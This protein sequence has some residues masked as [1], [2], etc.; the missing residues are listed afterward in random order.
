MNNLEGIETNNQVVEVPTDYKKVAIDYLKNMGMQLPQK[1]ATQFIEIAKLYNLNPFKREIYA[2]GYGQNFNI[3]VGYEVYLK[4][5]ER[6]GTLDG[7]EVKTI[8]EGENMVSE[9]TIWRKDRSHPYHRTFKFREFAQRK[10]DGTLNKFWKEKPSF[11]L[12]KV[13]TAI[14]FRNYFPDELGGMPYTA[15][16]LPLDDKDYNN[17]KSAN[18]DDE[19]SPEAKNLRNQEMENHST[20][21]SEVAMNLESLLNEYKNILNVKNASGNPYEMAMQVLNSN[22]DSEIDEMYV[23]CRNYL[24]AK[25]VKVA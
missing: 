9:I 11:M 4:R 20:K 15:D 1:F 2:V 8:G 17:L 16:E 12:E 5:A 6:I 7:W 23:R 13:A 25:G 18:I 10:S 21:I 24:L 3:I 22:S 19:L 14:G